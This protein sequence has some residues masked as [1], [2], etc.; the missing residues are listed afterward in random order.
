[1]SLSPRAVMS[2]TLSL[3][4]AAVVLAARQDQA[5]PPPSG[6]G[7]PD[8]PG[9]DTVVRVCSVCHEPR[10]AASVRLTRD[11]WADTIDE[12]RHR[13]AK[14]TDEDFAQILDYLASNFLGEAAKPLNVNSASALDLESV[15]GL[16]RKES[17]A[18]VQYREKNGPFKTL[19]DMKKVPG[20][21]FKKIDSRREYLVAF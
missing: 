5:A 9:K 6:E 20:L 12:M 4:I 19:D 7:L 13:G 21:D 1:M 16:L 11:G 18:V 14:G 3:A 17:A 8:G 10:R 15:A 2:L